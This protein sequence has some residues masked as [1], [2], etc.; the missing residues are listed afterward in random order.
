MFPA[1]LLLKGHFGARERISS[2]EFGGG[3]ERPG[4]RAVMKF[5]TVETS[6]ETVVLFQ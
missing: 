4:P 2:L 1:S 3:P 5:E 6:A